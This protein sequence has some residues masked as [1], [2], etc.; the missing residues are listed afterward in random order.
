MNKKVG[1]QPGSLVYTGAVHPDT[2]IPITY[3]SYN[4]E[5]YKKSTFIY[6]NNFP[7][8]LEEKG[9]KWIN[10]GGIH[11]VELI[12]K[13]G[14]FFK[15]DS[16]V[17]EDLLNNFQRPKLE[18]RDD[19]IFITLKMISNDEDEDR[20]D[21]E[22]ISFILFKDLLI[23]FQENPHDVFDNIRN[24]IEKGVGRIITKK[25][26]YLLYALIDRVVDNY[27]LVIESLEEKIENLENKISSNPS[28]DD[29]ENILNLKKELMKFKKSIFPLR[30]LSAKFSDDQ[31][32]EFIQEDI[33]IY[34]RDLQD[35]I[36]VVNEASESLFNR[37]T[38]LIQLYHSTLST[39]MNEIMKVLAM[40]STIFIPLSF[41]A[42][43]YG[44]N[45]QF[46]PE[47]TWR[48]GYF[49]VL[50][51]MFIIFLGTGLYFKK[52]KWW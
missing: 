8:E 4:H 17:L 5:S 40:I 13:V 11:N 22:Q 45:F 50:F 2:Q 19:F 48:Y 37:G 30:E 35:H 21:Y 1:L 26:D 49:F 12:K 42:G 41:L 9:A 3:Y 15:I 46:M 20:F 23:S 51:I 16:L 39:N 28:K 33:N 14:E 43:L 24:R 6:D 7:L 38:D 44:M 52:K 25:E 36:V 10:I 34:L 27:F 47:L 32:R 18:I 31:V 29:F